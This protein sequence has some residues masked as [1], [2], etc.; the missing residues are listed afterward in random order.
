MQ[1]YW[2]SAQQTQST[3]LFT[4]CQ[5]A[6]LEA[7]TWYREKVSA[8]GPSPCFAPASFPPLLR[9]VDQA[10]EGPEES[11]LLQPRHPHQ[12]QNQEGC[13]EPEDV[14]TGPGPCGTPT[15]S[16]RLFPSRLPPTPQ[17]PE[18]NKAKGPSRRSPRESMPL[19]FRNTLAKR[20]ASKSRSV[21]SSGVNSQ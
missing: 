12:L 11:A 2:R 10:E 8:G 14:G 4:C 5:R 19:L 21:P 13:K 1:G 20:S 3:A 9:R 16:G 7:V 6:D 17:Q 15:R 18:A